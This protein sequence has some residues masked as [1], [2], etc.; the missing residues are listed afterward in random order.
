[1]I[2][3]EMVNENNFSFAHDFLAS[4]PSIN[5]ID[6]AILKN[7]C[8][9]VDGKKILGSIAYEEYDRVGL[10]RYFV[11]KKNLSD[12]ILTNLMLEIEKMAKDNSME[13]LLCVADNGEIE[14]LFNALGFS[15]LNKRIFL[16]EE[17]IGGTSFSNSKFL[18]KNL[19]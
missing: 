11:F 18:S 6:D 12:N 13:K 9:V 8:I 10:I 15:I 3:I 1:M 19:V 5:E 16:N 4:V 17:K 14:T 7:G 2:Q